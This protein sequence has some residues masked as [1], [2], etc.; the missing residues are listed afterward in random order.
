M[1]ERM[2][3]TMKPIP[4]Q[5]RAR[6][7]RLLVTIVL[8]TVLFNVALAIYYSLTAPDSPEL[9]VIW[10]K[11]GAGLVIAA[12]T[13]V[14]LWRGWVTPAVI[15]FVVMLWPMFL[16][17]AWYYGGVRSP[18]FPRLVVVPIVFGL[19]MGGYAAIGGAVLTIVA[20][21]GLLYAEAVGLLP[22]F[23]LAAYSA[24]DVWA[25]RVSDLLLV[26]VLLYL[27]DRSIKE[28]LVRAR[29]NEQV[30]A[31]ANRQ[32]EASQASLQAQAHDLQRRTVQLETL[33]EVSRA[34]AASLEVEPLLWQVMDLICKRFGL[35]HVAVYLLPEVTAV[36]DGP[37][38]QY[39]AGSGE[40]GRLLRSQNIRVKVGDPSPV[41]SCLVTGQATVEGADPDAEPVKHSRHPLLAR[42]RSEAAV[43]LATRGQVLGAL[44]AMSEQAAEQVMDAQMIGALQNIADQVALA[45]TNALSFRR[46]QERLE[47]ERRASSEAS[48]ERWLTLLQ[49]GL[50]PGYR[51]AGRQVTP[52][53]SWQP[54]DATLPIRPEQPDLPEQ[55][56]AVAALPIEVRGETIGML[57]VQRTP[58]ETWTPQE[59]ELLAALSEQLGVALDSAR[60]YQETQR[61]AARE[62][63]T[64]V[65]AGRVR[66]TLDIDLVLQAALRE[67]GEALNLT[68][69]VGWM[70][71]D[72]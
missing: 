51:Y 16:S 24:L 64:S 17:E 45:L 54:D 20:G 50:T 37:A 70:G 14:L 67:I 38:A 42:A 58:G 69:V 57:D 27:A 10:I 22:A 2:R 15:F 13:L 23:D 5:E 3:R 59:T 7:A 36:P 4:Q 9:P 66:E 62:R 33:A 47:T 11:A 52:L 8:V 21:L 71:E 31:A 1:L 44:S 35:Y 53:R 61:R 32:L 28:N 65:V 6:V 46:L 29:H 41:G 49:E 18:E 34:T 40:E 55:P 60:L 72:E 30:A 19:L 25:I 39:Y 43:P 68:E 12:I 48:Q 63:L 26:A 56:G